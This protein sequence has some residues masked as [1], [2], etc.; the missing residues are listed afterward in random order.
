MHVARLDQFVLGEPFAAC[1]DSQHL[2]RYLMQVGS[3]EGLGNSAHYCAEP[4]H[5]EVD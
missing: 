4:R 5:H 3:P 1:P 2:H